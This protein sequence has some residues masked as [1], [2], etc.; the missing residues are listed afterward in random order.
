MILNHLAET[1][2]M[3]IEEAG[4]VRPRG[5]TIITTGDRICRVVTA[6][7]TV[8][9]SGEHVVTNAEITVTRCQT[10]PGGEGSQLLRMT[11]LYMMMTRRHVHPLI[12]GNNNS[13][14]P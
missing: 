10:Q 7:I 12:S 3:R 4:A 8:I 14:I 5:M 9:E 13:P 11:P 1:H 2:V 6:T